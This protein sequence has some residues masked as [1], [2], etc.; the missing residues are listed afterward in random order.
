[1]S[2]VSLALETLPRFIISYLDILK[3]IERSK[4]KKKTI[5]SVAN[6]W[7]VSQSRINRT[8][9]R[10]MR[11]NINEYCIS[12]SELLLFLYTPTYASVGRAICM[13]TVISEALGA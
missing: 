12:K 11:L 7:L 9:G 6:I 2:K 13:V 5:T 10:R 3:M 8:K 1:M 4:N